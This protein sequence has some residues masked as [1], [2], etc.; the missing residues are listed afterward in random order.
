MQEPTPHQRRPRYRGTHPRRFEERYK[1]HDP[2]RYS[3]EAAHIEA[4]GN[5]LAG[6]HRPICVQEIL[7]ILNPSPG[8]TGLDVTLG[9]GG[10]TRKLLERLQ[11]QGKLYALDADP[12]EL[13]KTEQRLRQQGW[14][15][16]LVVRQLNFASAKSLLPEV[17]GFDFVLADLGVSSMQLDNPERGFSHKLDGPLDLRLNP[18]QGLSASQW[19]EKVSLEKL[20]ETLADFADEPRAAEIARVLKSRP[21]ARTRET[22]ELLRQSLRLGPEEMKKTLQRTFMALRIAVNEEFRNLGRLLYALPELLKPGGKVAILTFHS[23]EDRRVKKAFAEGL[24][25][26][27]YDSI[28]PTPVRPSP[29]EQRANPRSSCAK[30]RW[31][32]RSSQ[33]LE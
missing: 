9:Y 23:G 6:S 8:Q 2:Q 32:V 26:G 5:T 15:E 25:L 1:E 11:P 13:A 7:Q 33:L 18:R 22:S 3:S 31:A 10:H 30:L 20:S 28:A 27:H 29:E 14:G 12:L 21:L 17:G 16:E 19:L 24:H 4:K